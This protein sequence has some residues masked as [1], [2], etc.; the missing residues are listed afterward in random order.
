VCLLRVKLN[1][2][3]YKPCKEDEVLS[4]TCNWFHLAAGTS[5][6]ERVSNSEQYPGNVHSGVHSDKKRCRIESQFSHRLSRL[7]LFVVFLSSPE[8]AL[9]VPL[10][11]SEFMCPSSGWGSAAPS[12]VLAL[13]HPEDGSNSITSLKT[14]GTL[15]SI[16]SCCHGQ[17]VPPYAQQ[18]T[19]YTQND[20]YVQQLL[21]YDRQCHVPWL[22]VQSYHSFEISHTPAVSQR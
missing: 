14:D 10:I 1:K 15:N 5:F 7:N 6:C 11:R 13:L 2:T 22:R 12:G 19:C 3:N 17:Q 9:I 8:N 4:Q 20:A 18:A 21:R 16:V